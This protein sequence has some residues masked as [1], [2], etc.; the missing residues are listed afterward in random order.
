[1]KD[2]EEWNVKDAYVLNKINMEK[3]LLIL[4]NNLHLVGYSIPI[5]KYINRDQLLQNI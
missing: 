3:K 4:K 5:E 1:M 2:P